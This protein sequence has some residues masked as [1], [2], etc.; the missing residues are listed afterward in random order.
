MTGAQYS[1]K[2]ANSD[3]FFGVLYY[4]QERNIRS[5][6]LNHGIK[7]VPYLCTSKQEKK[8]NP[9]E[10]FYRAE[11]LW[12]I[13]SGDAHDTQVQLDF[14]NKRL[15]TDVKLKMPFT[16]LLMKNIILFAILT[17][18]VIL[19]VKCRPALIDPN[20][21]M[22]IAVFGYIVCTSGIIYSQSHGMPMFRF[23]KDQYGNMFISE[24]FMRQQRS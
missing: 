3:T 10:S 7:T 21:W 14:I 20:L 17:A 16:T 8:R 23:D 12:F 15:S 13:K 2:Q 22:A 1:F 11:D 18:A 5:I 24:Y 19:L 6:F 9:E 4:S